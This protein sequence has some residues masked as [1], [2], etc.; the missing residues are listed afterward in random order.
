MTPSI[1]KAFS[2]GQKGGPVDEEDRL[3]FEAWMRG[4]CWELGGEWDGAC[5]RGTAEQ[6]QYICPR[7]NYIAVSLMNCVNCC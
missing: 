5:Y 3:A 7:E 1:E 4:H 6:G 2:I